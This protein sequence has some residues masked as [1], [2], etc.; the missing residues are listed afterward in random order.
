MRGNSEGSTYDNIAPVSN[1]SRTFPG[2]WNNGLYNSSG[3]TPYEQVT[4]KTASEGITD[5]NMPPWLAVY[6]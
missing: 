1:V 2:N 5:G 3:S 6:I 4:I